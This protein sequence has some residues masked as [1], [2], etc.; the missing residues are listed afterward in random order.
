MSLET[1]DKVEKLRKALHV[2]AKENPRFRFYQLYDKLYR[3]DVLVHAFRLC[4]AN[5]GAEGVDGETF[6]QIASKGSKT[7]LEELA[8]TLREKTYRADPVRRVW[9]PKANGKQRPLG[10]PTIRDRVVQTAAV[11]VLEPIFEAALN[12]ELDDHLGYSKH[13]TSDTD[14][15]RN[16]FTSKTL[17]T[18]DGQFELKTPR[19]RRGSFEPQLVKKRKLFPTDDSAKKVIYLAILDASKKWTMP[20]RNWKVALNRFMIEFEDRLADCI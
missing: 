16:G 3:W 9:I 20:I 12:A 10:I 18:E 8:N 1:P 7:W 13:E 2:K 14:N 5:G 6:E 19:D 11:L 4:R 17:R 15:S